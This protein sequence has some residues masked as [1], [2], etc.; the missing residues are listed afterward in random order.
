MFSEDF[1]PLLRFS[2]IYYLGD[3]NVYFCVTLFIRFCY[4]K[5]DPYDENLLSIMTKGGAYMPREKKFK[6]ISWSCFLA[7]VLLWVPNLVF[8]IGAG[9]WMLTY[10]IGPIGITFGILNK[11]ALLI[12][13]NAVMSVSFFLVMFIGSLVEAYL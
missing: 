4:I 2:T 7:C 1:P 13:L 6:I 11:S 3:T 10:V 12:V 9:F 5:S 8:Q